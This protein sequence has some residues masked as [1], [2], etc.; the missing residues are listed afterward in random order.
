MGGNREKNP[1]ERRRQASHPMARALND[2]FERIQKQMF[3]GAVAHRKTRSSE[4]NLQR[5]S[6]SQRR[7]DKDAATTKRKKR[8]TD[9]RKKNR[10]RK[11]AQMQDQKGKK[12]SNM[13]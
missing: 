8:T 13:P 10:K 5:T 12:N 1:L 11:R 4:S 7:E 9:G 6:H 2:Q 3:V